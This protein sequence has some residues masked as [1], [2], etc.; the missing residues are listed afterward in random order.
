RSI[1]W[2]RAGLVKRAKTSRRNPADLAGTCL[3]A[4]FV[5]FREGRA[6]DA[7]ARGL[8][9][10]FRLR[11]VFLTGISSADEMRLSLRTP[12]SRTIKNRIEE[13]CS[14]D[15]CEPQPES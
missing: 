5:V 15:L 13:K 11:I 4:E 14:S 3:V 1:T 9:R 12:E 2:Q 6:Y 10:K 8:D 7:H